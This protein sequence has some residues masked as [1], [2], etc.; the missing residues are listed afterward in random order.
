MKL[1]K[2][3]LMLMVLVPMVLFLATYVQFPSV[4]LDERVMYFQVTYWYPML[5]C[6]GLWKGIK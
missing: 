5:D 6:L 1:L 2:N 3:I 4:T